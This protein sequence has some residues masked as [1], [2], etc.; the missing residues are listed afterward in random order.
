MTFRD[1]LWWPV[2]VVQVI[3]VSLWSAGCIT[4][5]LVARVLTGNTERSLAMARWA[6]APAILR[7]G[8]WKVRARGVDGVDWS[9]AYFVAS[10]HRSLLDIPVLF[11]CLPVNLRFLVK[12]EL[13]SVPFLAWYIRAMG[14][15]FVDR[16]HTERARESI[17]R[18][19]ELA[20]EGKCV[21][22]FP[23]GTRHEGEGV[24]RLKAG[25]LA[26]AIQAGV[27]VLPVGLAGTGRALGAKTL[28]LRSGK[29]GLVVGEPIETAGLDP[30]TDRKPL[31]EQ[32]R[33]ALEEARAEARGL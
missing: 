17:R 9:R 16:H 33:R 3:L 20:R 23:E 8:G 11:H 10:N 5:A 18:I 6:W 26:A 12:Q 30:A 27:P 19:G 2:N 32:V 29:V 14:M 15:V 4:T 7:I 21:L 28:R 22:I 24:G 25:G 1:L 31:A 13:A